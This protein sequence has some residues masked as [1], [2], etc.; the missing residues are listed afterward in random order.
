[1]K[2]NGKGGGTLITQKLLYHHHLTKV[3]TLELSVELAGSSTLNIS[4]LFD[5]A[6]EN[7]LPKLLFSSFY[8]A[9][10]GDLKDILGFESTR[11]DICLPPKVHLLLFHN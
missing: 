6:D 2:E 10:G 5:W 11:G 3:P 8:A 4:S 1:M 9:G 7:L